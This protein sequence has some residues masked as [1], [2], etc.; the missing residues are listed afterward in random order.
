MARENDC[1]W[2][3]AHEKRYSIAPPAIAQTCDC[4]KTAQTPGCPE[5]GAGNSVK[6]ENKTENTV[7]AQEMDV[8][9][10]A[11]GNPGASTMG[12]RSHRKP[13]CSV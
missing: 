1:P 8:G 12:D 10:I 11:A 3:P 13:S 2:K 6:T 7:S 5:A 9:W 4:Q